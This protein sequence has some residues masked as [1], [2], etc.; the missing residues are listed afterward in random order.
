MGVAQRIGEDV[1]ADVVADRRER[2]ERMILRRFSGQMSVATVTLLWASFGQKYEDARGFITGI[3]PS[4]LAMLEQINIK[5]KKRSDRYFPRDNRYR[6]DLDLQL[7]LAAE[8]LYR[9]GGAAVKR[10]NASPR[11]HDILR[12]IARCVYY[13]QHMADGPLWFFCASR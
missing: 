10:E 9:P 2:G 13:E 4:R 5:F 3:L 8:L 12:D 7:S 11:R 1:V 6:R